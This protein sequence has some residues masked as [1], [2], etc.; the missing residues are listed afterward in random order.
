MYVI[1]VHSY[2]RT[3]I[4]CTYVYE[5][6]LMCDSLLCVPVIRTYVGQRL[7]TYEGHSRA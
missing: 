1:M 5:N 7:L 4:Y 6:V 2:I 3:Y